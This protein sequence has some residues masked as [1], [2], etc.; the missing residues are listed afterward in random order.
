VALYEAGPKRRD[1]IKAQMRGRGDMTRP[2]IAGL[3]LPTV[4]HARDQ[5]TT[6][7]RIL[8]LAICLIANGVAMSQ[9]A[10]R[11]EDG[12]F[13][14][15]YPHPTTD[16][17]DFLR[18]QSER[19]PLSEPEDGWRI[20]VVKTEPAALHAPSGNP[21]VTWIG[22]ATV[23][24]R[25]AGKNILVDPIFSERASPIPL[26][27]PRRIVPVP[28]DVP[29][30]PPIDIVLI[31]HNHYDHLDEPSVRRLAAMAQ[32][33]PRFLVPLG[34]KAWFAEI[35]IERVEEMDWWQSARDGEATITFV[36]VQHWS[37]RTLV[38]RDRTL[39]GGWSIEGEGL[40]VVHLGDTG[41][42]ADF[43]NI[44]ERLGPFDLALIPIGAYAPRWFMGAKHLD[45]AEAIQARADLRARRAIGIHWGTF[46]MADDPPDE[47]PRLLAVERERAGL[48]REDFDVLAIGETRGLR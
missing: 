35:G 48:T 1:I 23:L 32:R 33:S 3:T 31:T 42:S 41:Y 24:V 13:R 4:L 8:T 27:G 9:G 47:P 17:G 2:N 7:L 29:D 46:A 38:D 14:N 5:L 44:G 10:P 22:H 15:N 36:P 30:L 18:W 26:A 16:F 34:L 20:P 45:V 25:I 40:R 28:V 6:L 12:T 39:W 21:S 11:N 43:R 19:T 37:R